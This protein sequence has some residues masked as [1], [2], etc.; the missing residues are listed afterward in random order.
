MD[1]TKNLVD[2]HRTLQLADAKKTDPAHLSSNTGSKSSA[3]SGEPDALAEIVKVVTSLEQAT[4]DACHTAHNAV[5]T[6]LRALDESVVSVD[7]L[8]QLEKTDDNVK[9]VA[10]RI[11]SL[12]TSIAQSPAFDTVDRLQHFNFVLM[13]L[14]ERC[15]HSRV[16]IALTKE[17]MTR[18]TQ[19]EKT[20][21]L[22]GV[23]KCPPGAHRRKTSGSRANIHNRFVKRDRTGSLGA[24]TAS[25]SVASRDDSTEQ[26]GHGPEHHWAQENK[27]L[28]DTLSSQAESALQVEQGVRQL[29]YLNSLMADKVMSQ[30]DQLETLYRNTADSLSAVKGAEEEL[31][32][33]LAVTWTFKRILAVALWALAIFLLA[34]NRII[35]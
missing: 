29:S 22:G 9:M 1:L 25:D 13:I 32:K 7:L 14:R 15:S 27:M 12:S 10:D 26:R 24:E 33:P 23:V 31:R 28:Y 6:T 19:V 30:G 8:E 18:R 17:E 21:A 5:R 34:S 35:G 16:S 2:L 11:A 3:S 20:H 4:V